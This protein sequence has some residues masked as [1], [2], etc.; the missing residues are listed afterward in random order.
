MLCQILLG[1]FTSLTDFGTAICK[2]CTALFHDIFLYGQIQDIACFGNPL[3]K[4]DIKLCLFKR[5]SNL[6]L[7]NLYADPVSYNLP[8]LL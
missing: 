3:S 4:H 7:H 2:P 6:I 1:I 5:R 8:S